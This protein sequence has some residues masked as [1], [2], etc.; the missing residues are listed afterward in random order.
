[1]YKRIAL[2]IYLLLFSHL[3]SQVNAQQAEGGEITANAPD[4]VY[5][6]KV[7]SLTGEPIDLSQFQGKVMLIVNTASK[8][9]FTSQYADLEKIYRE[10]KERG[11]VVLGVPSND[12][13]SQEPGTN[14]QIKEFCQSR[15]GVTFP[16]LERSVVTGENKIE[17]YEFLTEECHED[18]VGEIKWNFEK[19]LIDRNGVVVDRFGSFTNPSSSVVREKIEELLG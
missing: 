3:T 11:F 9:G 10:Y 15:F 14:S 13:L 12:F 17:L 2:V 6:F 8:C 18:H 1:M 19:F 7:R 16:M 5:D 4:S